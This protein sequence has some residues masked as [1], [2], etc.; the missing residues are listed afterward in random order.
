MKK[1]QLALLIGLSALLI[2][3]R[4]QAIEVN[5]DEQRPL[6]LLA[7]AER[8]VSLVPHATEMLYEIEAE[9]RILATV[10]Y[11]DYPDAA[12]ELPR[13]GDYNALN[14]EAILTLQPDLIIAYPGGPT[15]PDVDRLIDLG[16]TVFFS[17]PQSL[18]E[19]AQTLRQLGA[20]TSQETQAE[21]R[22]TTFEQGMLALGEN[23]SNRTELSVFYEV[24]HDPFYTLNGDSFISHILTLCG[25][26][27]VF[28]GLPMTAPQVS[29]EAIL[30]QN[31][32]VIVTNT[33]RA[34]SDSHWQQRP[35]MKA[36]RNQALVGVDPDVMHRPTPILLAGARQLCAEL[37]EH[38]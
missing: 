19:I 3:A 1:P 36:V 22:A 26:R 35:Q 14:T 4:V 13:V 17:D 16:M 2:M 12:K 21:Q 20:L 15:R 23:Y 6:Q 7:P 31:P 11:A 28:A 29:L 24:W 9:H 5:D 30:A 10:A 27:N 34:G 32:D 18:E 37:D 33:Q 25:A 8:I 38:R